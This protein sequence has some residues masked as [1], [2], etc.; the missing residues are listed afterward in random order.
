MLR[1]DPQW[2]TEISGIPETPD[3]TRL[4]ED[5]EKRG[6]R[7]QTDAT[8]VALQ[9]LGQLGE[10][11]AAISAFMAFIGAQIPAATHVVTERRVEDSRGEGSL[12]SASPEA[13]TADPLE[14]EASA[15]S[16]VSGLA[17]LIPRLRK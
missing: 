8:A 5:Q 1:Q 6:L 11:P 12:A 14:D 2:A 13:K 7:D 15:R 4:R 10:L 16:A 17:A 9:R 3:E